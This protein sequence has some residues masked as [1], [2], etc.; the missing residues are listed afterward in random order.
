MRATTAKHPTENAA[1]VLDA[2]IRA[3]QALQKKLEREHLDEFVV[4]YH[5][6]FVGAFPDF[7]SAGRE[8]LSRFG[9]GPYLIQQVGSPIGLDA[10]TANHLHPG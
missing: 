7:N 6:K 8:A 2:D 5:G 3:F 10:D 1:H 9:K 4:F